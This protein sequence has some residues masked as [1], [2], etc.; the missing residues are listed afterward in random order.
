MRQ[1]F[2]DM[3]EKVRPRKHTVGGELG[4]V[5][6]EL[7]AWQLPQGKLCLQRRENSHVIEFSP[8][9]GLSYSY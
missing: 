8:I 6:G 2:A 5:G 1:T 7:G 3:V 4:A 9:R